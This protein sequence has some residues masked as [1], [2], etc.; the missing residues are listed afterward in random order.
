MIDVEVAY[1]STERVLVP[2]T[3][4]VNGARADPTGYTVNFAMVRQG[5]APTAYSAASWDTDAT[6]TPTR[7]AASCQMSGTNPRAR[8]ALWL[9]IVTGAETVRGIAGWV[10]IY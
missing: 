1:G 6:A 4:K 3:A 9:E 5:A 7:Y 2:V 8:Y 10:T